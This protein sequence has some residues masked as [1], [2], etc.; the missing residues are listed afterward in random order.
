M[1]IYSMWANNNVF[2]QSSDDLSKLKTGCAQIRRWL[3]DMGFDIHP[4]DPIQL[5]IFTRSSV[6]YKSTLRPKGGIT[7]WITN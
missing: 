5:E 1:P 7:R 4:T 3:R 2:V 6:V